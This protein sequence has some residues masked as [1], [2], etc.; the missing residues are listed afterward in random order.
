[1]ELSEELFTQ[2]VDGLGGAHGEE[3]AAPG[4]ERREFHRLAV[5]TSV[6]LAAMN[7]ISQP[8]AVEL[9]SLSRSGAA[10]LDDLVRH[11][12]ELLVLHLPR[13]DG[14]TVP[15]TCVVMNT[16]L[17][18]DRI[19]VGVRFLSRVEHAA[20]PVR[21]G[22]DGLVTV[23]SGTESPKILDLIAEGQIPGHGR[24]ARVEV[25][26]EALLCPY[27]ERPG[28]RAQT[29]TVRDVS[30]EGGLCI[31]CPNP[32]QRGEQ[33]MLMISRQSGI[34]LTL[35]CTAAESRWLD[36]SSYRVGATFS[37]RLDEAQRDKPEH[38]GFLG[39]LRRWLAA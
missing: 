13:P 9:R 24:D 26:I 16:R 36:D 31:V 23:P 4:G 7:A 37:T 11:V 2:L 10:V 25:N 30:A 6:M 8:R 28:G 15:L 39:R 19:R 1:M 33:F 21:T 5:S 20:A 3:P 32:M 27:P 18:G 38:D 34:P 17:R 14:S 35:I 12:G 22:A 29:V